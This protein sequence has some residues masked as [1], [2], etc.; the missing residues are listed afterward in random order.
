MCR[1]TVVVVAALVG[2]GLTVPFRSALGARPQTAHQPPFRTGT[3]FVRVDVYPTAG[4]RPVLDLGR[5]D[6]TILEDGVPQSVDRFEHVVIQNARVFDP[7]PA[8]TTIAASRALLEQARAR[9]F[10]IFLD[11]HHVEPD[12]SLAVHQP[13]VK[14]LDSLIGPDDLVGVMTPDISARDVT[15]ARRT[16]TIDSLVMGHWD[17]GDRARAVALDPTER[18]YQNC[19]PGLGP[20]PACADDDRG[21]A[22]EMMARRRERQTLGA[23]DDLVQSLRDAREER[24]AVLVLSD[25]WRLY[26]QSGALGRRLHCRVPLPTAGTDPRTGRL[27]TQGHDPA[28]NGDLARCDAERMDL[29]SDDNEVTFRMLLDR[30]NRANVSFYSLD[31]RGVVVFDT[32]L[33]QPQTG[34]QAPGQPTIPSAGVD[35]TRLQ[36]RQRALRDLAAGTDGVAVLNTTDLEGGLTRIAADLSSYYLLGYYSTGKLDGRFHAITVRIKRPGVSVRAR[37]GFLAASQA[38]IGRA[39]AVSPAGRATSESQATRVATVVASLNARVPETPFR[40]AVASIWT[41]S[42]APQWWAIG[43]FDNN[44]MWSAGAHATATILNAAGDTVATAQA[45]IAAGVRGFTLDLTGPSN[46]GPGEYRLQVRVQPKRGD[47]PGQQAEVAAPLPGTPGAVAAIV[48][49]RGPSTGNRDVPSVDVRFRR[50][51][52]IRVDVADVP[53]TTVFGR[54]LDRNGNPMRIPIAMVP[55]PDADGRLWQS[56]QLPLGPLAPGD[57]VLEISRSDTAAGASPELPTFVAFRVVP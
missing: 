22:D 27:T 17:W 28:A 35:A 12:I 36:A 33:S 40:L 43:E 1:P 39:A 11:I 56:A 41:A 7:G 2:V 46:A 13:L 37:R 53:G 47:V 49:R 8:P 3:N 23:L 18:T 14:A 51:E 26:R 20:T 55:A 5:D 25:G 38:E 21:V 16:S 34:R 48:K 52:R 54:L 44:D 24:K 9:V 42:H 32:P 19:Y 30:A 45:P 15:F 57:F 29:A 31:P 10:V 4:G 6:F 50:T